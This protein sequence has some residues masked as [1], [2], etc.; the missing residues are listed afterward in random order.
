MTLTTIVVGAVV[1]LVA[2]AVWKKD[3]VLPKLIELK[4][5]LVGLVSKK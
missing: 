2:L 1:V 3:V 5:K 4:D